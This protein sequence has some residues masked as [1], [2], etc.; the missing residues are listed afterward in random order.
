VRRFADRVE[1]TIPGYVEK[2]L[3]RFKH[4]NIFPNDNP[5][6]WRAA[7]GLEAA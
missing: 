5:L 6:T 4:R 2:V 3:E 7:K 1:L